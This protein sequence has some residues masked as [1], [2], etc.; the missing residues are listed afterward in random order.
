[1]GTNEPGP[2]GGEGNAAGDPQGTPYPSGP[3][4]SG[5]REGMHGEPVPETAWQD[6]STAQ[7]PYPQPYPQG[8]PQPYPAPYP[9][10]PYGRPY[11][12]P[13]QYPYAPP[14][15]PTNGMAVA[16]LVLGILWLYWIGSIL[17]LIF[18][19][20]ARRQIRERGEGGDGMAVAGIVL[21]WIGV[22]LIV[23]FVVIFVLAGLGSS[24]R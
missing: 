14:Y 22:G 17:A 11:P 15:R 18:G 21:G 3:S 6:P 8:Y 5:Y 23:V 7:V 4:Y 10:A 19:Y 24:F 2:A 9:P 16:S 12:A 20:V 1:M 13:G